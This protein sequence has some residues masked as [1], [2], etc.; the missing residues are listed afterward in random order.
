MKFDPVL[1]RQIALAYDTLARYNP[2]AR[3]S[4]DAMAADERAQFIDLA[5][6]DLIEFAPWPRPDQPYANSAAMRAD[7]NGNRH[8]WVFIGGNT[9][10]CRNALQVYCG[11]AVHDVL[12][13][14][15]PGNDF[16][17]DG[18]L[19][20]FRAHAPHYSNAAL[21]ALACDNLGQT[22]YYYFHPVNEGKKHGDRIWPEQKVD[23]LPEFLWWPFLEVT[24]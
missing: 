22:A 12:G 6:D 2:A 20:A 10:P 8:L 15:W 17:P 21:P 5:R 4:F 1:G 11:R 16:S 23:L 24:K 3:Y 18:E 9:H 14:A 19:A 7:V 13:H